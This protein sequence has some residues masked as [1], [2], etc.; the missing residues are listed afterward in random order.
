MF[1]TI[2]VKCE[3]LNKI[4]VLVNEKPWH[5]AY[6]HTGCHA[7]AVVA[8][9]EVSIGISGKISEGF[10]HKNYGVLFDK[11]RHYGDNRNLAL[12]RIE[13]A[14]KVIAK[15]NTEVVDLALDGAS[16]KWV[17]FTSQAVPEVEIVTF[18]VTF[19]RG[20][21][22]MVVLALKGAVVASKSLPQ[23]A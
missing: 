6:C 4:E 9:Y 3:D 16:N 5:V 10:D 23:S 1:A 19:A 8:P 12:L 21:V 11:L 2:D 7:I 13:G 14:L 15:W 20:G 18:P 22:F 17:K